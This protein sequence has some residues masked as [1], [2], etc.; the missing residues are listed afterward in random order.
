[1]VFA[2]YSGFLHY[3]QLASHELA[4]IGINVTK[5]E[6]QFKKFNYLS[7][8]PVPSSAVSVFCF[9]GEYFSSAICSFMSCSF[10]VC[11]RL[12]YH[13]SISYIF[14]L[15]LCLGLKKKLFVSCNPTLTSFYLK[16]PTPK[17]FPPSQLPINVKHA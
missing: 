5:N 1:M 3:L 14:H 7:H 17:F 10:F 4:T 15:P 2:G 12:W 16:K 6:I 9:N 13:L 8:E 11:V